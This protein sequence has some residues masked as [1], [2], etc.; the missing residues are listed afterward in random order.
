MQVL[1]HGMGR[2][3]FLGPIDQS[4]KTKGLGFLGFLNCYLAVPQWPT[5]G[6]S[7]GDSITNTMFIT[8]FVQ[9]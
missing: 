8:A 3:F 6:H 7:Q 5:L 1:L 4:I 9:F 2:L